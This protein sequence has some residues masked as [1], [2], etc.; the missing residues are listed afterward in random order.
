LDRTLPEI[1]HDNCIFPLLPE[2]FEE[3]SAREST[4]DGGGKWA[5]GRVPAIL[6]FHF[7]I[8]TPLC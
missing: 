5:A 3:S 8:A 7:E 2:N 4:A 1:M 6:H